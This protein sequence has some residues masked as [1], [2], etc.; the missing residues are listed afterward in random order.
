METGS[1]APPH[2]TAGPTGRDTEETPPTPPGFQWTARNWD[3]N[4]LLN[5]WMNILP[6]SPA[7]E[8]KKYLKRETKISFQL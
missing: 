7:C 6:F 2:R 5:E 3:S 4:V 1:H 8:S